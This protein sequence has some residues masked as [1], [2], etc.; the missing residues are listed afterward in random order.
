M[1]SVQKNSHI[2]AALS[3]DVQ[4]RENE[5][6]IR[7]AAAAIDCVPIGL[8]PGSQFTGL[9][10]HLSGGYAACAKLAKLLVVGFQKDFVII[11]H[12]VS[13]DTNRTIL[14]VVLP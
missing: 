14:G 4:S 13:V 7:S 6:R 2:D 3:F 1:N 9:Y 8:A 12:A 5:V 10:I 11:R